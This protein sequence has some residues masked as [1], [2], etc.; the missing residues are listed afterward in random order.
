MAGA[1]PGRRDARPATGSVRRLPQRQ[2][3]SAGR[4]AAGRGHAM[5]ASTVPYQY[6]VLRC[7]PRVDRQEFVN[8]GVVLYSQRLDFL[9]CASHLDRARLLS[10]DP[11]LDLDG[12]TEAM[13]RVGSVC[14]GDESAGLAGAV[15]L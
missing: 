5:S 1:S 8:V 13:E 12:V 9:A 7:V 14:R 4:L 11:D 15:G 2:A 6:L 10:L 3:R